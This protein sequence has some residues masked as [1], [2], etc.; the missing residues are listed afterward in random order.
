V[1]SRRCGSQ[2]RRPPR[3][4]STVFKTNRSVSE[5]GTPVVPILARRTEH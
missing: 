5:S 1:S 3:S 4:A 2:S